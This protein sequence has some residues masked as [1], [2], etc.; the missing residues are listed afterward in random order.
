MTDSAP[1]LD[2]PVTEEHVAEV[3]TTVWDAF[4]GLQLE[5]APGGDQA[6]VGG[7][8]G[9]VTISGAWQG[10]VVLQC[11]EQHAVAAAEAM[12]EAEPGSLSSEEVA[13]ALGELT[14]M[15]GGNIKNLLPEPSSL[16]IPSVSGGDDSRVF[17]P[18]ARPVLEVPLRCGD[19]VI[20]ITVWQS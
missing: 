1:V 19:T 10:A 20:R 3:A 5:R 14:N 11:S 15:V 9:V 6:P 13:D 4:L 16:S 2:S 7:M 8:S 17:V 18:A 12:F